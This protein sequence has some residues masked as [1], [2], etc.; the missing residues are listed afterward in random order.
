MNRRYALLLPAAA[1]LCRPAVAQ[2]P[3]VD[4]RWPASLEEYVLNIRR[5]LRSVDIEAFRAVVANP[6]GA[7]LIDVREPDELAATGRI[8]GTVHIPRGLLE[9]RIWRTMGHPGP[10]DRGRAIFTHC[11]NG[12]R[13]TLS[14]RQLT[15]VGFTNVTAV[16]MDI[17]DW[18]RRGYPLERVG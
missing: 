3:P 9:F 8:P 15:D 11:A 10:V 7:L 4:P 2:T 17:P 5:G 13:G 1:Y 6:G 16:V 12:L 14:A 18:Q